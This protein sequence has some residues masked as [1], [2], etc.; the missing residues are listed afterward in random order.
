LIILT[1]IGGLVAADETA[2]LQ[3]MISRPLVSGAMIGWLLG[4]PGSGLLL[5][6]ILELLYLDTLPVGAAR[7]PDSGLATVVGTGVLILSGKYLI[8]PTPGIWLVVILIA[9][10]TGLLGGWSIIFVRQRNA[11]LVKKVE[12]D[13]GMGRLSTVNRYQFLGLGVSFLRG[14][15]L[16]FGLTALSL[17]IM[18][19]TSDFLQGGI[20]FPSLVGRNLIICVSLAL[21]TRLFVRGKT[22]VYFVLRVGI[23]LTFLGLG[24]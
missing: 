6:S 15:I 14:V 9:I 12:R 22:L 16:T 23:T 13:L 2:F 3:V 5:G 8:D 11:N 24:I 20:D 10:I 4:D 1:L 19:W 18:T 21:A 7:F 17:R